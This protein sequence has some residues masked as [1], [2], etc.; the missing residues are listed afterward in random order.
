MAYSL[1]AREEGHMTATT[2]TYKHPGMQGYTHTG[3]FPRGAEA[4]PAA[5]YIQRKT[6][7]Q[8]GRT[9]LLPRGDGGNSVWTIHTQKG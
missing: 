9:T 8:E 2:G 6:H 4:K 5:P 1:M 7:L 3:K